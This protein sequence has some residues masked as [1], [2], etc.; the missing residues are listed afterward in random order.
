ML[1]RYV[2][3][4]VVLCLIA[5]VAAL[6][7]SNQ[8]T[9]YVFELPGSGTSGSQF[10]GFIYNGN[11]LSPDIP[12]TTGPLG[13]GQI[14]PKPDGSKFYVV[15]AGG[16]E[17]FEPTFTKQPGAVNGITGHVCVAAITPDGKYLLVGAATT[18]GSGE[19]SRTVHL[20]HQQRHHSFK[21]GAGAYGGIVG[22]AISPDSTTAWMLTDSP[23]SPALT[24]ISL[25][26]RAVTAK[27]GLPYGD[28]GAIALA[29]NG[30][31][32]VTAYNVIYEISPN[33]T[34]YTCNQA[35]NRVPPLCIT[36]TGYVQVRAKPGAIHFTPSGQTA[37]MVNTDLSSGPTSLF[38]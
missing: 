32:Y 12:S 11:F 25:S 1:N 13:T 33:S 38:R 24:Q 3:L 17:T 10:E 21:H 2:S 35:F 18:C 5:S 28:L 27:L 8:G 22:F 37:Y 6:G 29:P 4:G 34:I 20:G 16:L 9:G 26:T 30:L 19:L 31:I 23:S 15:G 14:I 36:P 7:Q